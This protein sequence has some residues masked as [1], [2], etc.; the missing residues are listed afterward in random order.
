MRFQTEAMAVI[1]LLLFAILAC[2]PSP[3]T[4]ELHGQILRVDPGRQEVT[5]KHGD[6]KGFMPGMTM[7]FKVREGALLQG[8]QAGDEITATLV[9]EKSAAYLSRIEK[10]GFAA[11]TESS[12]PTRVMDITEA[13]ERIRTAE[14]VDQTGKRRKVED[15]RGRLIAVTFVYTRCPLPNYCPLL[16]RHFVAVQQHLEDAPDLRDRVRL[17]SVTLDP[18]Y[19][20]PEVLAA[21]AAR[22]RSNPALWSFMTGQPSNIEDFASQFGVSVIRENAAAAEIVHNLRTALIDADGKLVTVFSGTEWQPSDL[23]AEIRRALG[24]R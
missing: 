22:L 1:A 9:V 5:I 6:I 10:T 15:W 24:R 21:H 4:Y 18:A 14:L 2:G 20:T 19:D 23:I 12:P 17:V 16:D 3:P 13:G 8:R 11:L 7:A